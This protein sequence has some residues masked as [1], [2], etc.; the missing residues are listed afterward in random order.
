[1][2]T[3]ARL[4]P[5]LYLQDFLSREQPHR[6]DYGSDCRQTLAVSKAR[7]AAIPKSREAFERVRGTT[8]G[9]YQMVARD[10][11]ETP[12]EELHRASGY[13]FS[14]Q[15]KLIRPTL[16]MAAYESHAGQSNR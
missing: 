13:Y 3:L 7:L 11:L 2:S 15:G 5:Q 8:E 12:L 14:S 10:V 4:D 9:L 16:V 1:M 6:L